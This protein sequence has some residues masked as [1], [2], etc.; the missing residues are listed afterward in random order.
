MWNYPFAYGDEL[1][2]FLVFVNLS[3]IVTAFLQSTSGQLIYLRILYLQLNKNKGKN[4]LYTIKLASE[5]TMLVKINYLHSRK[6]FICYF[7]DEQKK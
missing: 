6:K 1:M 2:T 7:K 5:N 4:L 3:K